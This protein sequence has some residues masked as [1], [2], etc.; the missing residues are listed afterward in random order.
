[1]PGGDLALQ[2]L[3]YLSDS[4]QHDPLTLLTVVLATIVAWR[5]DPDD[6]G[7]VTAGI[8]LYLAYIVRIGGDFMSGRF[9]TPVFLCAVLQLG[10]AM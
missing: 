10:R 5:I 8:L 1:M 4:I 7:P 3:R 2:G 9:L 6:A